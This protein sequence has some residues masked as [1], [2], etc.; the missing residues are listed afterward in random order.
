MIPIIVS[1]KKYINTKKQAVNLSILCVIILIILAISIYGILLKIDININ[2][3]ELPTVYIAGKSGK[4]YKYAYGFIILSAILTSAI[5]AGY[6]IL[7]NY[8]KKPKT[9]KRIA[10]FL[11]ISAL[12]VSKIGFSNLINTLYPVFGILGIIQIYFILRK[13]Q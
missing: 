13:K 3:V 2:Q 6:S 10:I 4:I 12:F 1:L 9:Y 8:V 11:C 5:A 7:E